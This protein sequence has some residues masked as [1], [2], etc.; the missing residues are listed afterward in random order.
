MLEGFR[1]LIGITNYLIDGKIPGKNENDETV[2]DEGDED[3]TRKD[4]SID[5]LDHVDGTEPVSD[6]DLITVVVSTATKK[7][8]QS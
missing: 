5:G 8:I 2:E 4:D 1:G 7:Q 6:I 3:E